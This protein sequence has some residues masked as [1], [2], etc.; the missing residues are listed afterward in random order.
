MFECECLSIR[1]T[2]IRVHDDANEIIEL[3]RN[4]MAPDN[5]PR[6]NAFPNRTEKFFVFIFFECDPWIIFHRENWNDGDL[7]DCVILCGNFE[8]LTE[9]DTMFI[10][11][12]RCEWTLSIIIKKV[13]IVPHT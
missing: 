1:G 11:C 9:N 6:L 13:E 2:Q 10:L 12:L 3:V 8:N 4:R 7:F 5:L